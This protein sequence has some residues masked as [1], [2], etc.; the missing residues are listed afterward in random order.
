MFII[1]T[2]SLSRS[3]TVIA[4]LGGIPMNI[5]KEKEVGSKVS[6]GVE[7]ASV[8]EICTYYYARAGCA[9]VKL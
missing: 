5:R 7:S 9:H 8:N 1:C 2:L 4:N 3:L 6:S